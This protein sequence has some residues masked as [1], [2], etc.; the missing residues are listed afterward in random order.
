MIKIDDYFVKKIL[1]ND[2]NNLFSYIHPNTITFIGIACN[3]YIL[4]LL[5]FIGTEKFDY[6]L[7]G[8][9]LFVRYFCDSLD[10]AVARKY[11]KTSKLGNFLD[12]FSDGIE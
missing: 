6:F 2:N 4:Y 8:F 9:L 10:G 5:Q 12:S 11:K 1:K 3:L 7:I